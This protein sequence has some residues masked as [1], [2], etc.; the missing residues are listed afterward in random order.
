MSS[1]GWV[2][3]RGCKA[4]SLHPQVHQGRRWG[5]TV[6]ASSSR[7]SFSPFPGET[8]TGGMAPFWSP[9]VCPSILWA[10]PKV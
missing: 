3:P 8:D 4:T 2:W 6:A 9:G 7:C 10:A 1:T 5:L